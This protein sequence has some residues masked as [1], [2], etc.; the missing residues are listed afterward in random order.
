MATTVSE[1]PAVEDRV[2]VLVSEEESA[3]ELFRFEYV[4]REVTPPPMDH[5][6]TEQEERVEVLEGTLRCRVAGTELLLCPGERIVIAPGVAHAVW[7]EDPLGSRS[8]GE[9]RPAINAQ[10]MFRAYIVA[11]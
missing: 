4:A 11:A 7:S 2:I 1:C 10:R 5:V 9:Y 6:H 3:G 8:I